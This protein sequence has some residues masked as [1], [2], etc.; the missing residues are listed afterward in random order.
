[1]KQ[2]GYRVLVVVTLTDKRE[3][4][5]P[6]WNYKIYR[7]KEIAEAA[8]KLLIGNYPDVHYEIEPIYVDNGTN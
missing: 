8:I 7:T 5:E 4:K 3:V 1:M 2:I 6:H